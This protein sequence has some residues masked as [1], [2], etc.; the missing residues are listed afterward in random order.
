MS[1][2]RAYERL[3]AFYSARRDRLAETL[4]RST[5]DEVFPPPS[6][7]DADNLVPETHGAST[8]SGSRSDLDPDPPIAPRDAAAMVPESVPSRRERGASRAPPEDILDSPAVRSALARMGLLVSAPEPTTA[9]PTRGDAEDGSSARTSSDR[10]VARPSAVQTS[11][12]PPAAPRRRSRAA[13]NASGTTASIGTAASARITASAG[14][15]TDASTFGDT[16]AWLAPARPAG[17]ARG[18]GSPRATRLRGLR[19]DPV[20]VLG[21]ILT[22]IGAAGLVAF[23]FISFGRPASEA[24]SGGGTAQVASNGAPAS[25]APLS[26][27]TL[28]AAGLARCEDATARFPGAEDPEVAVLAAYQQNGI[29]VSDPAGPNGR[30]VRGAARRIVGSW[31]GASLLAARAGDPS[32]T[33]AEWAGTDPNG[34]TLTNALLRGRTLD[35]FLSRGQWDDMQTSPPNTC[36]G[37]FMRS[38]RNAA[39]LALVEGVVAP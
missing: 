26:G 38:P 15:N 2:R 6:L 37:P 25:V 31:I 20:V 17:G 12:M 11:A 19:F 9:T 3:I 1:D 13:T 36:E 5:L 14:T 35:G 4:V 33:L 22:C 21:F 24:G 16:D 30:Y 34:H 23:L 39:L 10:T 8:A 28:G 27:A 7:R 32:P 18:R 29:D